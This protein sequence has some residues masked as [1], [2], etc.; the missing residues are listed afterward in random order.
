LPPPRCSW[1]PRVGSRSTSRSSDGCLLAEHLEQPPIGPPG[2][3]PSLGRV[4]FIAVGLLIERVLGQPLASVIEQ[5]FIQPLGLDDTVFSDGATLP[6]RHGW[7]GIAPGDDVAS[8]DHLDLPNEA[9]MTTMWASEAMIS[10]STDVLDWTEALFSGKVLGPEMTALMLE[11]NP[12][13]PPPV[14]NR[15]FGLGATGY[16][17]EAGCD[18][19]DA[20]LVGAPATGSAAGRRSWCTTAPPAPSCSSRPTPTAPHPPT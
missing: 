4:G 6:T 5:R 17:L 8:V 15:Y 20:E 7:L 13:S 3:A 2:G 1:S 14:P 16:C 19:N 9:A 18:P 11:M 12:V 10:S